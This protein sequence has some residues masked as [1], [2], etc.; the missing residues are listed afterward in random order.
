MDANCGALFRVDP[1]G[2]TTQHT[3]SEIGL[4]NTMAWSP[5]NK[6]FYFGDSARNAMYAYDIDDG[7]LSNKR[8]HFEA[9][10]AVCPTGLAWTATAACGTHDLAVVVS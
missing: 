7:V 1:D 6:I 3:A 4:S 2:T 10:I 8:I 9:M 5:D